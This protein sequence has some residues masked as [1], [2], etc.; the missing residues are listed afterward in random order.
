MHRQPARRWF[1]P[2]SALLSLATLAMSAPSGGAESANFRLDAASLQPS[3]ASMQSANFR[4]I[5]AGA[6][7]EPLAC[8]RSAGFNAGAGPLPSC[9]AL[10]E[11]IFE[12]GFESAP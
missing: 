4:L 6:S 9:A 7:G 8:S 5:V 1:V 10:G 12:D 2:T 3:A 11:T